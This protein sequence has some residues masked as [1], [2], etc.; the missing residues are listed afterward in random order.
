MRTLLRKSAVVLAHVAFVGFVAPILYLL[1]PFLRVRIASLKSDRIGHLATDVDLFM[2]R[3]QLNGP[4]RR[5]SHVFIAGNPA[6]EQLLRMWRRKLTIIESERLNFLWRRLEPIAAKTP[7][8]QPMPMHSNEHYEFAMGD[9]SLSFTENEEVE[10]R[11]RLSDMGVGE[12]DWFVCFHARD[13]GYIATRTGFGQAQYRPSYL[14]CSIDNY[15]PAMQWVAAQGGFAIRVGAGVDRP[16]PDLGPRAIDYATRCRTDFMDIYLSAKCRFFVGSTSG[17]FSIPLMFNV[18]IAIANYCPYIFVTP[19]RGTLYMPKLL[20]RQSDKHI[21]P[22]PE[23]RAAGLFDESMA[24]RRE[25]RDGKTYESLGLEW[26]DNEPQDVVGL[27]MDMVDQLEGKLTAPY[28]DQL[29]KMYRD[30]YVGPNA[31]PHGGRLGPRFALRHAHLIEPDSAN[32]NV[33]AV[34]REPA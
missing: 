29:Q 12:R 15:V 32:R 7:F 34:L 4:A 23:L 1:E 6:N 8:L 30:L 17:L 28:A 33:T 16:L 25:L 31:S 11:R 20:R 3:N 27:C 18:P 10:G 21:I 26:V 2:R 9:V 13:P 14:D 5:A 24:R 19:G 22:F